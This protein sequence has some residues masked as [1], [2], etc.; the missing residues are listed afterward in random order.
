MGCS[1]IFAIEAIELLLLLVEGGGVDARRAGMIWNA[2]RGLLKD[3]DFLRAAGP[4]VWGRCIPAGGGVVDLGLIR[5]ALIDLGVAETGAPTTR[6]A[7]TVAA[8]SAC[9][10]GFGT[11]LV[12]VVNADLV[13]PLLFLSGTGLDGMMALSVDVG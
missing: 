12:S 4:S 9:D 7:A 2:S 3:T 8:A 10:A 13:V 5:G 6:L 11:D 1:G